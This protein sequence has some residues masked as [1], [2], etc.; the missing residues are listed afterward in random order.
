MT[1]TEL[2]A[3]IEKIIEDGFELLAGEISPAIVAA[4]RARESKLRKSW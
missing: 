1:P 3:T 4:F 2:L